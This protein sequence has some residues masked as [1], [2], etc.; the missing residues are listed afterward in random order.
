[1]M[2]DFLQKFHSMWQ[3]L[4]RRHVNRSACINFGYACALYVY[5]TEGILA[6]VVLTVKQKA[7]C[8]CRLVTSCRLRSSKYYRI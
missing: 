1:M 6:S 5:H 3:P 2:P 7:K 4:L 8:I